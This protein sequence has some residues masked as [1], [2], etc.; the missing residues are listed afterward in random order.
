[1]RVPWLVPEDHAEQKVTLMVSPYGP[2]ARGDSSHVD[3]V[4]ERP[5][6]NGHHDARVPKP[7]KR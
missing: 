6:T 5:S 7:S 3:A 4:V 1:V 2:H